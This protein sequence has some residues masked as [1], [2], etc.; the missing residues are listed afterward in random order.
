MTPATKT[1]HSERPSIDLSRA[2]VRSPEVVAAVHDQYDYHPWDSTQQK[3][4]NAVRE[5][6]VHAT[7]AIIEH[8]PA[9][10]DRSTALRNLREARMNA[11]SAITH[12]GRH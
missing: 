7:L 6:L 11:N 9:C 1:E 8:A 12:A 2:T 5:A 10:A 4:G 3:H